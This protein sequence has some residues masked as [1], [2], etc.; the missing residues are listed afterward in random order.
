V[1]PVI[2]TRDLGKCYRLFANG[3][4]RIKEAISLRRRKYHQ[5][6]WALKGVNLS[7]SAGTT[8]GVVG[9]NGAGK[10][11]LLKILTGTTFPSH[12]G[13][14]I[15]GKVASLLE[16]G[17]GFHQYFTGRENIYMNAAMMG[18][19]RSETDRKFQEILDFSELHHFID[20]PIRT[21]SS[22]MICRLGFSTAIA[23]DPDV[24]IIDEILAVG[25]MHFQKKCVERIWDFKNRG[26]TILFCSHSLYD[27]RQLCDQAMWIQ[28]GCVKLVGDAITVTNEYATYEKQLIGKEMDYLKGLPGRETKEPDSPHVVEARIVDPKSGQP[29]SVFKPGEALDVV[30]RFK[31]AKEPIPIS[32]GIGFTRTDTT[33][34]FGHTTE[35]DGV[36]VCGIE[37][38]VTLHLPSVK[39]LSGEFVVFVWVMDATGV[40][41]YHQALCDRNLVVQNRGKEVGLFLQDHSWT[42]SEV[43]G[44]EVRAVSGAEARAARG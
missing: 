27:V 25:D 41:R 8:V 37:G 1:E 6:I 4:G 3:W 20:A 9:P 32:F 11:T 30:V 39:L 29:R 26:K 44:S 16:L 2:E 5:E 34:C 35:M 15:R 14:R 36:R 17:A 18:F 42:V 19:S 40:H 43:G 12:G 10:S 13:Y 28:D 7:V 38:T 23:V 33:L 24:L 31:N 21:Y 22:G